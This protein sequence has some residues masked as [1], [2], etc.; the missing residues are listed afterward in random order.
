MFAPGFFMA[1]VERPILPP[2][3]Y[4]YRGLA[5]PGAIDQEI[6]AIKNCYLWCSDF[7]SMNDPM[8]GFYEPTSLLQKKS[9]FRRLAKSVLMEKKSIG[10]CCFSD[11]KENELMWTH[12]ASNYSGICIAYRPNYLAEGLPD[13]VHLVRL[14]YGDKPPMVNTKEAL[15][16]HSASVKILSQKKFNWAYEREWRVLG[17]LGS[18]EITKTNCITHL[19]FGSRITAAHKKR[20]MHEFQNSKLKI[21]EM[22]VSDYSHTWKRL[23]PPRKRVRR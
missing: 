19:Y 10:I 2:R 22:K 6:A 4:R 12:Y 3:L 1:K 16:I 7:K 13:H 23:N 15:D 17:P 11:T 18:V 21:Y 5:K 8:E 20:I 9:D 14:S